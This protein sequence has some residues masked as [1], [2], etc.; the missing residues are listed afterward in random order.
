MVLGSARQSPA[1]RGA[2]PP[3][4]CALPSPR[5]PS[6]S[7][8]VASRRG[9]VGRPG[10]FG[11]APSPSWALFLVTCPRKT[12]P[13]EMR[14]ELSL[15]SRPA[16]PR[17]PAGFGELRGPAAWRR[18]RARTR[19]GARQAIRAPACGR[20]GRSVVLTAGEVASCRLSCPGR[21]PCHNPQQPPVGLARTG[22]RERE[23]GR[24]AETSPLRLPPR[25]AHGP[26]SRPRSPSRP[27]FLT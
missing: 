2:E 22:C 5:R 13:L 17:R 14:R 6:K 12:F 15:H 7:L 11:S 3:A 4:R 18:E 21:P 26:R 25:A 9:R 8:P 23:A 10:D 19:Q 24:T 27:L 20:R 1:G 16:A